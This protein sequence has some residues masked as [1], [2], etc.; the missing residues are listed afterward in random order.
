M[1]KCMLIGCKVNFICEKFVKRG[2]NG[3][4][5]CTYM[6]G[7]FF[8]K[9]KKVGQGGKEDETVFDSGGGRVW[10]SV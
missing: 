5:T 6:V 3:K 1:K 9:I 2:P 8:A 4:K 10:K 7:E